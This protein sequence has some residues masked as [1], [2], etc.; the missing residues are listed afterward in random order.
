M[1]YR[2]TEKPPGGLL[3]CGCTRFCPQVHNNRANVRRPGTPG[4]GAAAQQARD[5]RDNSP[6]PD[7]PDREK[8]EKALVNMIQSHWS[9][10]K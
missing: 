5:A 10:G 9:E 1:T 3:F 4:M 8:V 2:R 7:G 6:L